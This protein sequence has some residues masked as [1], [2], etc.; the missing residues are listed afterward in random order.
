MLFFIPNLLT[1]NMLS[2]HVLRTISFR[3]ARVAVYASVCARISMIPLSAPK[4]L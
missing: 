1:A 3:Q 2:I 4:R